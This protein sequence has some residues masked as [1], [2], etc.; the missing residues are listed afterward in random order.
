[1]RKKIEGLTFNKLEV[2]NYGQYYIGD[3]KDYLTWEIPEAQRTAGLTN[4]KYYAYIYKL[5]TAS[6]L[7]VIVEAEKSWDE[8]EIVIEKK[9]KILC[10][11][12]IPRKSYVEF[13]DG[14]DIGAT[15]YELIKRGWALAFY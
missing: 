4:G 10:K 7:L 1:M 6:F 8:T 2:K 5:G 12:V 11:V 13:G 3:G 15:V 14:E 9:D